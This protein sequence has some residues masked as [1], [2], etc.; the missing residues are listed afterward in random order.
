M[1][2]RGYRQRGDDR[3]V[4]EEE[5]EARHGADETKRG[6]PRQG[7]AGESAELQLSPARGT[8]NA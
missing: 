1:R 7:A 4:G 3:E 8:R 5:G 6:E 2:A